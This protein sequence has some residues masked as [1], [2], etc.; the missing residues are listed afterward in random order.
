MGTAQSEFI[1]EC[2]L[3]HFEPVRRDPSAKLL[4]RVRSK[5]E[6]IL[7]M[8][9]PVFRGLPSVIPNPVSIDERPAIVDERSRMG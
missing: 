9:T 6:K 3:I 8:S 5:Y 7:F 2:E 1:S 4:V